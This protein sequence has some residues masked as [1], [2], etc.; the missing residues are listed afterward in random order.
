MVFDFFVSL[1]V[2]TFLHSS[3]ALATLWA[4]VFVFRHSTN[5]ASRYPFLI[6]SLFVTS[7]LLSDTLAILFRK[8]FPKN[9]AVLVALP[10]TAAFFLCASSF[11]YRGPLRHRFRG[12]A[13]ALLLLSFTLLVLPESVISYTTAPVALLAILASILSYKMIS[14]GYLHSHL[15]RTMRG[16]RALLR[17]VVALGL[18]VILWT[19]QH[20]A[21]ISGIVLVVLKLINS[22][23]LAFSTLFLAYF[24]VRLV[25]AL[26]GRHLRRDATYS[27]FAG[28]G[29]GLLVLLAS[30]IVTS[31]VTTNANAGRQFAAFIVSAIIILVQPHTFHIRQIVAR[32]FTPDLEKHISMA[33]HA[34]NTLMSLEDL[35]G[36]LTGQLDEF[37]FNARAEKATL[38]LETS[39]PLDLLPMKVSRPNPYPQLQSRQFRFSEPELDYPNTHGHL[40]IW[41][42]AGSQPVVDDEFRHLIDE[43][44]KKIL[45]SLDWY[46][47]QEAH[48]STK[49]ITELEER[50][51]STL[52][53]S[54]EDVT[55]PPSPE[56]Y[57][58][59]GVTIKHQFYED[60]KK[61]V[62]ACQESKDDEVAHPPFEKLQAIPPSDDP[63]RVR[64]FVMDRIIET[65]VPKGLKPKGLPNANDRNWQIYIILL[66]AINEGCRDPIICQRIG[67]DL[68]TLAENDI[69]SGNILTNE[70]KGEETELF[71]KQ[72]LLKNSHPTYRRR[73]RDATDKLVF[74]LAEH[75]QQSQF[76]N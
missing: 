18:W 33:L 51:G 42:K 13:L 75:E 2:Q 35:H 20:S 39:P 54:I 49:R 60:V 12:V 17:T 14:E 4:C 73:K 5:K 31:A 23:L 50:V 32:F 37:R 52:R 76:K 70:I 69:K 30:S 47:F 71:F 3:L 15:P 53:L 10:I 24:L 58:I 22:L 65:P 11:E 67:F 72:R 66:M 27:A 64:Q 36:I 48:W 19:F 28:L 43:F 34:T 68:N 56:Y 29:A 55:E 61:W 25:S 7:V 9:I 57:E 26:P 44:T 6:L 21:D 16:R 41:F 40:E 38:L 1:S 62:R 45:R 59:D 74:L 46:Y 8:I 63:F